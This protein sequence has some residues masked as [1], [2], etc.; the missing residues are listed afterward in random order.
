MKKFVLAVTLILSLFAFSAV[1]KDL[2]GYISDMACAKKDAAKAE[3][4]AHAG[5]AAG[6]AKKGGAMALVSAGK[7]Y[8]ITAIRLGDKGPPTDAAKFM[9]SFKFTK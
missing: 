6:C 3:S 7:V 4:D 9:D 5:C 8:E 2:S 1:A